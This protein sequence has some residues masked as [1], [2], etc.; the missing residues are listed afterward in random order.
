MEDRNLGRSELTVQPIIFGAWAAGGWFWGGTDDGQAIAAIQASIDAGITAIDTAPMYGRGHSER[1]VGQAIRGRRDEVTVMT[2]CGLRWD[3]DRGSHFF[4]S[5]SPT[6]ESFKVHRNLRAH[7]IRTEV[8]QSLTRMDLETIDLLQCHW[9]DPT[10]PV[11]ETMDTLATL[12]REGKIR[13]V[14]VSNF[15][16]SL[17][18]RS[19]RALGDVPLAST[20]PH[21][22]LVNRRIERDILPWCRRNEVGVIAYSPMERGLLTGK[23]DMDRHFPESD[24]RSNDPLFSME[25]RRK[26]LGALEKAREMADTHSCTLAQLSCA[27]VTHQPGVTAAIVGARN[28]QQAIENA[29][30]GE[31]QLSATECYMLGDLFGELD[32]QHR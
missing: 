11:E 12:H 19:R 32:L 29:K 26:V 4:D 5:T 1:V 17:L 9:P 13:A 8:E 2:K 16:E 3:D 6:G 27:W 28:P 30:A 14:G 31:I 15:S 20:Q 23:I 22:S 21:Y 7:S 25:N 24:G 10:T 18:E